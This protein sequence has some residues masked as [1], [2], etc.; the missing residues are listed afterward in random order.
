MPSSAL[1]VENLVAIDTHVHI[2]SHDDG[3][4]VNEAAQKYFG[5]A[6]ELPAG[7]E[8]A[9]YYRSRKMAAWSSPWTSD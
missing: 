4:A 5:A 2:E 3:S 8:I 9:E 1:N 7:A 6:S